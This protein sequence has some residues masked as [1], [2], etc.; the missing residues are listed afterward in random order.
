MASSEHINGC[1]RLSMCCSTLLC[2]TCNRYCTPFSVKIVLSNGVL[3]RDDETEFCGSG[4]S[5]KLR[6]T[7]NY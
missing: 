7:F 3:F 2:D 4:A 1:F 5:H 6:T